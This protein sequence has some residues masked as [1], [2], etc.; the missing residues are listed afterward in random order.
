MNDDN[1]VN[2][3]KDGTRAMLLKVL[4]AYDEGTISSV[5]LVAQG[6]NEDRQRTIMPLVSENTAMNELTLASILLQQYAGN[7]VEYMIRTG[8][9]K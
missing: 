2:F 7:C 9:R 3:K 8:V 4:E 6:V 5:I 1:V